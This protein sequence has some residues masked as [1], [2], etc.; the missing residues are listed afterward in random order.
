MDNFI[1]HDIKDLSYDIYKTYED[2]ENNIAGF[3]FTK[4]EISKL[5]FDLTELEQLPVLDVMSELHLDNTNSILIDNSIIQNNFIP[6]QIK[7]IN[8]HVIG[9]QEI[10][11]AINPYRI[12]RV[13]YNNDDNLYMIWL[14][15]DEH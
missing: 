10:V 8:Q 11:L 12:L 7:Q 6:E 9:I 15:Y 2:E 13:S 14:S 4:E 3:A 1:L 5:G